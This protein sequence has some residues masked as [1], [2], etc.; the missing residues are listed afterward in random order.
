[1]PTVPAGSIAETR[2][3]L[4]VPLDSMN[5]DQQ[6][7]LEPTR[8]ECS[9]AFFPGQILYPTVPL[10]AVF[11]CVQCFTHVKSLAWKFG[12]SVD[13]VKN[14]RKNTRMCSECMSF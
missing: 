9:I 1:M 7:H 4:K 14:G 8:I 12:R 11:M 5:L 6:T 2:R 3:G 10:N 13:T